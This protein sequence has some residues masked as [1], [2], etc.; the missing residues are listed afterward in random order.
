VIGVA[1]KFEVTKIMFDRVYK[2]YVFGIYETL[3]S[4]AP[5]S[6]VNCT[7]MYVATV[8]GVL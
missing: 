1:V 5:K 6:V 4:I 2:L 7:E 3:Y 8:T